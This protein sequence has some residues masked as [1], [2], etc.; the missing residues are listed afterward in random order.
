M[1]NILLLRQTLQMNFIKL[2]PELRIAELG[3]N[4]IHLFVKYQSI[5]TSMNWCEDLH[6]NGNIMEKNK[7]KLIGKYGIIWWYFQHIIGYDPL[8]IKDSINQILST[9]DNGNLTFHEWKIII[10][11]LDLLKIDKSYISSSF[12]SEEAKILFD[13]N[14][15]LYINNYDIKYEFLTAYER[16]LKKNNIVKTYSDVKFGKFIGTLLNTKIII[17]ILHD[18]LLKTKFLDKNTFEKI[19][20]HNEALTIL[21]VSFL[22]LKIVIEKYIKYDNPLKNNKQIIKLDALCD[23]LQS[24]IYT[25]IYK[26]I[27]DK[28]TNTASIL[29]ENFTRIEK[30]YIARLQEKVPNDEIFILFN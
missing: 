3:V 30:G 22:R 2:T 10:K 5:N 16:I 25:I 21:T 17:N 6:M 18:H 24:A 15:E 14:N 19:I 9:Y 1:N 20:A 8:L 7:L 13:K 29:A 28:E 23:K 27:H 26:Y 12:K 11:L 4:Y